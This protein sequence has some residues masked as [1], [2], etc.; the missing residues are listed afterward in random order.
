MDTSRSPLEASGFSR[1]LAATII[2]VYMVVTLIPITWMVA[3]SFKS[4]DSA[5]SYPPE[6]FFEPS[7]EGYVNLFT[8]RSRQPK[9]YLDSLPPPDTWYEELVRSREMVITGPSKFLPRYS[10]SLIIGFGATFFS[11]FLGSLA[12][13][14]LSR[15]KVPLKDD[16]LFFILSTRMFPPIAVAVPIF[17][18]YRK[19]GLGDTHVGM[20]ILYTVVNL[21]LSVWLLKGFMDEIPK[22]YEEAAMI[23]GYSRMQ[24]FFKVVLPQATTGIAATAIFCMIFSWNEYAFAVLLTQFNA[25]TAP[26]FIPTI[27]GEG[28]LDWPAIGAGTTLFLIPVMIFTVVLRKHLLR[29]ITFGA[30]RK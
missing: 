9:D 12:A 24:A 19:L 18:M 13:Y 22:E 23:D 29:G 3:T 2:I 5:I 6:V 16:L 28:G 8:N 20:I 21:S 11:V 14:A 25:Q 10:N 27:I 7:L 26:P 15:F 4:V 1:K 30:V 17:I